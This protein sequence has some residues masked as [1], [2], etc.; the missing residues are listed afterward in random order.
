MKV[1]L[2]GPICKDETII[3]NKKIKHIGGIVYYTGKAL[4]S[5]G[6]D[7][8]LFA[9]H[10]KKDTKWVNDNLEGIKINHIYSKGTLLICHEY[11]KKNPNSRTN[12]TI[13]YNNT[14]FLEKLNKDM[15]EFDYII[16]APLFH[17]NTPPN[18]FK[19][20]A[21]NTK[22]KLIHGNFGMFTY[23]ENK[24]HVWKNPEN[25]IEVLPYLDYLFLDDKETMFVSGKNNI[26]EAA[27]FFLTKG[28]KNMIVTLGNNGSIIYSKK[29]KHMIKAFP[30][31]RLADPTGAGDTYLAGFIKAKELFD[32]PIK[33][34]EFAAMTATISIEKVGAFDKDTK[35]ILKRINA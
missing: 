5:L 9:S 21:K 19:E 18:L 25:I 31:K 32:S 26:D 4:H 10:A 17:D 15:V 11:D 34:A 14:I 23:V 29:Y 30:P 22:A 16:L 24:E 6:I 27:N 2:I 12:N 3:G 7:V 33:Q 35:Y 28:L 20:L 13:Y 8:T 1:A